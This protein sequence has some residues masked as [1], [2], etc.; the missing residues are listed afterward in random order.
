M[1]LIE[2]TGQPASK[3]QRAGSRG[4]RDEKYAYKLNTGPQIKVPSREKNLP[5]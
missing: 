3:D 4:N 2:P 1:S 5:E